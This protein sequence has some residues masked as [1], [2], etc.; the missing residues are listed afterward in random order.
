MTTQFPAAPTYA[1]PVEK[2]PSTGK[3]V[4]STLWLQWFL[5]VAQYFSSIGAGGAAISHNAL[6]GIQ[7]G[8]TGEYYHLSGALL[9]VISGARLTK[10]TQ[11]ADDT[12]IDSASKGL[13]LKDSQA[14]PHYWRITINTL[15]VL[16]ITD[17]GTIIP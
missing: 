14:T 9:S 2:D 11:S 15:G 3:E 1:L 6:N 7:G 12:V 13:V 17:L 16:V 5:Q 4:F 10:S 8:V